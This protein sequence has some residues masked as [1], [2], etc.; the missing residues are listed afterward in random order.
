M[1]DAKGKSKMPKF[2]IPVEVPFRNAVRDVRGITSHTHFDDF[3]ERVAERMETRMS[4]LVYIGWTST[5]AP[6]NPKPTPKLLEDEESFAGLVD[7]VWEYIKRSQAKYK[8]KGVI[9]PF[10]IILIDT[11]NGDTKES[12]GKKVRYK[13]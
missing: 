4:L 9:N 2:D 12:S 13:Q 6:K 3:L 10:K 1:A 7:D 11:S 8:G 5:Y